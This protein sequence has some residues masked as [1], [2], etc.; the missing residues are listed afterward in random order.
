MSNTSAMFS[1]LRKLPTS[2]GEKWRECLASRT[3]GEKAKPFP[4]FIDWMK[5]KKEIWEKIAMCDPERSSGD[6]GS[7]YFL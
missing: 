1:L 2:V 7:F 3:E 5:I 6:S 4:V